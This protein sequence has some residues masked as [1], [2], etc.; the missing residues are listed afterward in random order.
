MIQ[1]A[2][3]SSPMHSRWSIEHDE[4][5][6][7]RLRL[8]QELRDRVPSPDLSIELPRHLPIDDFNSFT[9][10]FHGPLQHDTYSHIEDTAGHGETI[11]T[12]AHHASALTLSAGLAPRVLSPRASNTEYDASRQLRDIIHIRPDESS[13]FNITRTPRSVRADLRRLGK[14]VRLQPCSNYMT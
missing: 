5:D 12:A 6:E 9:N 1:S 2:R 14:S 3:T 10:S 4:E 11:S 8:E 13:V 7:E